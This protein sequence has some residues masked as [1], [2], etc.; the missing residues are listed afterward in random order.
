VAAAGAVVL[1]QL[2]TRWPFILALQESSLYRESVRVGMAIGKE[3]QPKDKI[4]LISQDPT[5]PFDALF[6]SFYADRAAA[7]TYA[8]E[9]IAG[10]YDQV[11]VYLP[12][13]RIERR[14]SLQ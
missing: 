9:D 2:F 6:V 13:G 10:G 11:F 4:L 14:V 3:T 1:T 7:V 5:V 8:G 12:G